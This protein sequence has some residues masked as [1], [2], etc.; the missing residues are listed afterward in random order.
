MGA[1][2]LEISQL[3]SHLYRDVLHLSHVW[4][5]FS[6]MN[7]C[8]LIVSSRIGSNCTFSRLG[9]SIT[10]DILIFSFSITPFL[11]LFIHTQAHTWK[12]R[13]PDI[14]TVPL[15]SPSLSL[16]PSPS[17]F[18]PLFLSPFN[19][20]SLFSTLLCWSLFKLISV[21]FLFPSLP[22]LSASLPHDSWRIFYKC[23]YR[24][25]TWVNIDQDP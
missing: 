20:I 16:P 3:T 9:D 2:S 7:I 15:S 24:L 6:F 17:H 4:R 13:R 8:C 22:H 14:S 10:L 1:V 5:Y 11:S 23:H 21:L 18:Y 19:S 25:E 12:I